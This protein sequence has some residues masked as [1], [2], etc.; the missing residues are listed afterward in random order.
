MGTA[1]EMIV[2]QAG[3][4]IWFHPAPPEDS[5]TNFHPQTYEGHTVLTWWQ[6]CILSLG[7]GQGVDKIYSADYQPLAQVHA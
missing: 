4:L 5:A 6:G 3:N 2:D 7:F 1:G